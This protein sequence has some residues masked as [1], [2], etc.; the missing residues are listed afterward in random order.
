MGGKDVYDF[1]DQE[2]TLDTSNKKETYND[3]QNENFCFR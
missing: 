1:F 2:N 3:A